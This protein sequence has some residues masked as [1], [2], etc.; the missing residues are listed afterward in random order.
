MRIPSDNAGR[1]ILIENTT[2]PVFT[3]T[4]V[5]VLVSP[6]TTE[7]ITRDSA[8]ITVHDGATVDTEARIDSL[9]MEGWWF[10]SENTAVTRV[11]RF[12]YAARVANG[13]AWVKV[14]NGRFSQRFQVTMSRVDPGSFEE[15]V[16]WVDGSLEG[17]SSDTIFARVD[18]VTASNATR[19]LF[20]G[21]VRNEDLFC[22]DYAQALTAVAQTSSTYGSH[23][24]MT[25]ITPRHVAG[26][27]HAIHP[28]GSTLTWREVDGTAVSRTIL[29]S[30]TVP[31][32][33]GLNPDMQIYVLSSDL[34]EGIMPMLVPPPDFTDYVRNYQLGVPLLFVDRDNLMNTAVS[35]GISA[36]F[37]TITTPATGSEL[38]PFYTHPVGGTSGKPILKP[39]SA[40]GL[41]MLGHFTAG[42]GGPSYHAR[43]WSAII[44]AADAAAGISTGYV[45][46]VAVLAGVFTN[47]VDT[48]VNIPDL[49]LRLESWQ[50]ETFLN[51][52]DAP[53]VN[54]DPVETILDRTES[55][56]FTSSV[57]TQR[58]LWKTNQLNGHGAL[59]LDAVDDGYL[60]ECDLGVSFT[61]YAV[62]KSSLLSACRQISSRDYNRL[63][64]CSRDNFAVLLGGQVKSNMNAYADEWLILVLRSDGTESNLRIN[65]EDVTDSA[66][67]GGSFGRIALGANGAFN[68]PF[69]GMLSALGGFTRWIDDTE[70][71][72]LEQYLS[73][74]TGISLP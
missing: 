66:T 42:G 11:D 2:L 3:V 33:G 43:N 41:M 24:G 62:M 10:Q 40:S 12:G 46:E 22:A 44:A 7:T 52:S 4:P 26:C 35:L 14:T 30:Y 48:L 38:L 54:N 1:S 72:A 71:E 58:G 21:A 23:I 15:L 64:S 39:F 16:E 51:G 37:L 65:G 29:S 18:G 9:E 36:N 73:S 32:S 59:Q 8:V 61:I 27:S 45:P 17:Y 6:G 34:P 69:G 25:A 68:E 13:S 49:A 74:Q 20:D 31:W 70:A 28:N 19:A 60:S 56:H 57:E 67:A 53:A 5:Q 55:Y 50:P 63:I 47:F